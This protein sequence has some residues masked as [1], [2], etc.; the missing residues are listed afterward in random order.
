MNQSPPGAPF[1]SAGGLCLPVVHSYESGLRRNTPL[2]QPR[3][4]ERRAG[5]HGGGIK[6][7]AGMYFGDGVWT[8]ACILFTP[9][10]T[11]HLSPHMC[12]LCALSCAG[13]AHR[14]V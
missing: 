2:T 3:H 9:V 5:N 10:T 11:S 13:T 8:V 7:H 6:K 14:A 4:L 12:A 1:G